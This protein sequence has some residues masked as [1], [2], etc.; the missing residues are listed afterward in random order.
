MSNIVNA[1]PVLELL[2]RRASVR[3]YR[4]DPVSNEIIDVVLTAARQAPTSSNLQAYSFV[5]IRDLGIKKCLARLAGGQKHIIDAP[6]FIAI[7][8]DVHRLSRAV[9]GIGKT[10]AKDHLEMTMVACIDAAL[11]G[12]C[13]SLSADSL[14]LGTVMIGGMRNDP[15][16]VAGQLRL[17]DGV[18]VAFGLCVGWP[19]SRPA[20]KPRLPET[21]VVHRERYNDDSPSDSLATYEDQLLRHHRDLGDDPGELWTERIAKQFSK[22]KR[23]E[24]LKILK[25]RGF[26]FD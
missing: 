9:E 3:D 1:S 20:A 13:A 2:R 6:V 7:C 24:L 17:P 4:S 8:A 10:L 25:G 26:G 22:P 16:G 5:V 15:E 12:M 14:G 18:F 19:N 23:E 21:L 11:V